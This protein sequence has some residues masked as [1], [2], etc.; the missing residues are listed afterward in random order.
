[1]TLTVSDKL[2]HKGPMQKILVATTNSGKLNEY[3]ELLVD[4]PVEW[5]TLANVGLAGMD[6]DET[7]ETFTDNALLKA[8]QYRRITNFS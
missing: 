1:V 3:R 8:Q 2:N 7:G 5:L 6:V 4:I